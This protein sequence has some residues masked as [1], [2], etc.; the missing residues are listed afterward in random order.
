MHISR[1]NASVLAVVLFQLQLVRIVSPVCSTNGL[2]KSHF[3]NVGL[4]TMSAVHVGSSWM[5]SV[6][7]VSACTT[8]V[9]AWMPYSC[10]WSLIMRMLTSDFATQSELESVA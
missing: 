8:S 7:P 10:M 6:A 9:F 3:E 1:G 2:A 5:T 4:F